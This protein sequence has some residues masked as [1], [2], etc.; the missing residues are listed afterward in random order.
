MLATL[1]T[2]LTAESDAGAVEP[3]PASVLVVSGDRDLFQVVTEKTKV[4]FMGARG[5][6]PET[7]DPDLVMKRYGVPPEGLP[8][9]FALVGESADNIIGVPGVGMKTAARLVTEHRTMS[10]LLGDLASVTPPKLQDSLA[11]ASE[12]L[13]KNDALTHLRHDVPL[14]DGPLV[15]PVTSASLTAVRALFEALE[16]K[17]LVARLDVLATKWPP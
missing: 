13:R 2:R 9:L 10:S 17:S 14:G 6:K 8:M 3:A 4:L 11:A 15:S 1:A 5:Q 16:M 7:V 12:R